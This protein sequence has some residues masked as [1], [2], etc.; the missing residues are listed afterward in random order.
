VAR[1]AAD[2]QRAQAEADALAAA[3]DRAAGE[4]TEA[5]LVAAAAAE[6]AAGQRTEADSEA[7]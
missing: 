7:A 6:R 2:A 4:R 5:Q 3:V 1:L